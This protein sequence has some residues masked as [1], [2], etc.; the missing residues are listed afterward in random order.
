MNYCLPIALL[1]SVSAAAQSQPSQTVRNKFEQGTFRN[2]TPVGE[3]KYLDNQGQTELQINYDSGNVQYVRPDSSMHLLRVGESWQVLQPARA[4]RLL[5]SSYKYF[6]TTA[7]SLRY[8]VFALRMHTQGSVQLSFVV[9]VQLSFVVTHTGE[10]AE[11]QVEQ[12][13][14]RELTEEVLRVLSQ[15]TDA[16]LPALHDGKAHD[17][18][19]SV[20]VHFVMQG[21]NPNV[22]RR[23][24]DLDDM[25]TTTVTYLAADALRMQPGRFA[26]FTVTHTP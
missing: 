5:G 10:V 9:S 4:P 21:T 22:V 17:A 11:V 2:N 20:V 26:E 23:N 3:W 25:G 19:L 6:A 12:N 8:P 1:L 16:W 13:P 15:H 14:G 18:R 24:F 7:K